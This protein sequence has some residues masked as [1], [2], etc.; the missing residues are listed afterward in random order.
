[1]P[2]S[3]AGTLW[4]HA[5][6]VGE[7]SVAGTL[8]KGLPVEIPLVVST[9]TPTGQQRA[10]EVFRG[11]AEVGYLPFELGFAVRR[12]FRRFHPKALVLVEGDLWPLVLRTARG[13]GVPTVV[14]N[15]RISDRSFP[16]LL[17]FRRWLAP[18]FGPVD[19]FAM[20]TEVDRDRLLALGVEPER[21]AVTGNLKFETALP[22]R[23]PTL[24][25]TFEALAGDRPI[26]IAGSTMAGE[27]ELVLEAF[28]RLLEEGKKALLLLVPRHPE[29]WGDVYRLAVDRGFAVAR[30]S[31]FD[32]EEAEKETEVVLL[33]TLGELAALYRLAASAFIGGTLVAKGG[34]NPLES[35]RFGVPT[36]VGPSMENFREMAGH[37]D[38]ASAWRRVDSAEKLA[39]TWQHWL[40]HPEEAEEVGHRG[41]RLIES[42][43]G[44]LEATLEVLQPIFHSLAVPRPM[45]SRSEPDHDDR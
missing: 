38:V 35:A 39:A 32:Q 4:I 13:R 19:F 34:H 16:R 36:V 12:W 21:V 40:D 31:G 9:I 14:I 42:H 10:R 26:L 28:R 11:R 41:A 29:R 24:E 43:R 2:S 23:L 44:A 30:R 27:D 37:F 3:S 17:R 7:V 5:V 25:A 45:G 6:S 20:Q 33:D 15:G 1:M 22:D 18:L 8:A